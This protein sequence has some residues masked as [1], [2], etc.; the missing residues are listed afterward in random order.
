MANPL[1]N[2]L[3]VKWSISQ[4]LYFFKLLFATEL[5]AIEFLN[6][7]CSVVIRVRK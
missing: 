4:W 5:M 2:Y 6:D 3:P 1:A 7:F